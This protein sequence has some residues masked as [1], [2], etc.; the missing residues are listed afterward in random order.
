MK[1]RPLNVYV[2]DKFVNK[3]NEILESFASTMLRPRNGEANC[4]KTALSS[5]SICYDKLP[6]NILVSSQNL[7][8]HLYLNRIK[9]DD[10]SVLVNVHASLKMYIGLDQSPLQFNSFERNNLMTTS[11]DLGKLQSIFFLFLPCVQW[12]QIRAGIILRIIVQI[13]SIT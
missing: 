12:C 5:T 10:L 4:F 2:E 3:I 9:I 6:D 8:S 1:I 13:L 11:Y 7:A